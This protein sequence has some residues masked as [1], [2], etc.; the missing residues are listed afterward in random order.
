[1]VLLHFTNFG[2]IGSTPV[3]DDYTQNIISALN[4]HLN[5]NDIVY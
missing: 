5:S 2:E 3:A 4:F 1:M